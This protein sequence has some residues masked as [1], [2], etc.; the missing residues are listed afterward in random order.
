MYWFLNID[1]FIL[2]TL[3]LISLYIDFYT[4]RLLCYLHLYLFDQ[5]LFLDIDIFILLPLIFISSSDHFY[6]LKFSHYLQWFLFYHVLIY[7]PWHFY[8]IYIDTSCIMYWFLHIDVFMLLTIIVIFLCIDSDTLAFLCY[9]SL[10]LFNHVLNFTHLHF[11][12]T[13]IYTYFIMSWFSHI[14]VFIRLTPIL[15]SELIDYPTLTLLYYLHLHL[16]HYVLT[17][18]HWR[19]YVIYIYSYLIMYWFVYVYIFILLTL[20]SLQLFHRVF[21]STHLHFYISYTFTYV[22]MYWFLHIDIFLLLKLIFI[23]L[24][25]D[26]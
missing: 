14:N 10:Y 4:L 19:F 12:I 3:I 8:I 15:I 16:F 25:I 1:L 7:T 24:H 2:L 17:F 22:F 5:L 13:Y 23:S 18:R 9:L 20:I 6:T 26:F 21:H 11:Y